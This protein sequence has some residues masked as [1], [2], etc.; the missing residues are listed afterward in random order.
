VDRHELLWIVRVVLESTLD[1][2]TRW[3]VK[4]AVDASLGVSGDDVADA[5]GWALLGIE[6]GGPPGEPVE[7]AAELL[8]LGDA[9]VNLGGAALQQSGHVLTWLLAA[10]PERDDLADL[11]EGEADGLGAADKREPPEGGVVVVTVAR[12]GPGRG[13]QDADLLVVADRLGRDP[14]PLGEFTD[15]H[16]WHPFLNSSRQALTF[17]HTGRSR[18]LVGHRTDPSRPASN[19]QED[20][21]A[22]EFDRNWLALLAPLTCVEAFYALIGLTRLGEHPTTVERLA[23]TLQRPFITHIRDTWRPRILA[24]AA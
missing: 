24:N 9:R 15:T 21:M 3:K 14:R 19:D 18:V 4:G 16:R 6:G 17:Q 20:V 22:D 23:A 8:E 12:G 11:A 7:L 10:V 2:P 5:L 1:L 13:R